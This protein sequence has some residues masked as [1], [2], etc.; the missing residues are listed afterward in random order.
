[1][2]LQLFMEIMGSFLFALIQGKMHDYSIHL[3]SQVV[4]QQSEGK[5]GMK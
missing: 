2:L 4:C 1:M 3:L 5:K